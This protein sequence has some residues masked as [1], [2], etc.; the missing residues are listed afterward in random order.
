MFNNFFVH[1]RSSLDRV[2]RQLVL[3]TRL[4]SFI[5]QLFFI[6][7][8]IYL[9]FINI[10]KKAFLIIYSSLLTLSVVML[11]VEVVYLFNRDGTRLEKRR[12]VENKRKLSLASKIIK[13]LLKLAVI[14]L[15]GYEIYT[16]GATN[17]QIIT[18]VIMIMFFLVNIIVN[19]ITT[20][21]IQDIDMIRLSFEMDIQKSRILSKIVGE[22]EYTDQEHKIIEGIETKTQKFKE[23]KQKLKDKLSNLLK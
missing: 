1:T 20:I 3:L 16:F 18:F 7:Y 23:K 13:T 14:I 12:A 9:I 2:R 19:I 11:I 8:Y 22:K 10:D 21:V 6:G 5:T 15:S 17:F 4:V